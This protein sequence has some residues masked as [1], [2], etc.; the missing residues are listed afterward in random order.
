MD[1]LLYNRSMKGSEKMFELNELLEKTGV[2]PSRMAEDMG[3]SRQT[4]LNLRNKPTNIDMLTLYK[5]YQYHKKYGCTNKKFLDMLAK[6]VEELNG[7]S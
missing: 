2:K 5:I 4:L 1:L 3:I 7:R 6:E